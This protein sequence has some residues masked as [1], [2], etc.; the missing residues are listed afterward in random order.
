MF[1]HQCGAENTELIEGLCKNCFLKD[2]SILKIPTNID[3][4]IC[5][6][7]NAKFIHGKWIDSNIIEEE[8]IYRTLEDSIEI[9]PKIENPIIDLDI[10]Q[11]RGKIAECKVNVVAKVLGSEIQKEYFVNVNLK[12]DVCPTCSKRD[13]GYYE[14]VLQIR[15][16]NKTF[17]NSYKIE[18][19]KKID[20]TISKTILKLYTK[21]K[22][23]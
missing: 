18:K 23:A 2:F 9:N 17:E 6:H 11:M 5:A 1:C 10:I 8:I 21:D 4:K 22:L 19:L 14:S 3:V 20:E 7:C 13:S 16:Q 15:N 12:H